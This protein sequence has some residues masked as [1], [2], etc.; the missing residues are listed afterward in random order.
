MIALDRIR[1][2][3]RLVFLENTLV[4]LCAGFFR[5]FACFAAKKQEYYVTH[6]TLFMPFYSIF[7]IKFD[8]FA[9]SRNYFSDGAIAFFF[10]KMSPAESF[11][12]LTMRT[13]C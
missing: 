10:R 8:N 13:F 4:L 6:S 1:L 12:S 5:Y 3:D 9:V 7:Q 11:T 2:T